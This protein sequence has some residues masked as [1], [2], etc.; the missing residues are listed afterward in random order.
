MDDLMISEC[1]ST[2]VT[3]VCKADVSCAEGGS[4]EMRNIQELL[5]NQLSVAHR[6]LVS[7]H[8]DVMVLVKRHM[9]AATQLETE[10]V[11][12]HIENQSLRE[13]LLAAGLSV[14]SS[15]RSETGGT[16]EV[17]MSKSH[18]ASRV[19][20]LRDAWAPKSASIVG[21]QHGHM[22][23]GA[24]ANQMS[25]TTRSGDW[26]RPGFGT[27]TQAH[28]MAGGPGAKST[29]FRQSISSPA[30]HER[31]VVGSAHPTVPV[32]NAAETPQEL[33]P[34][35]DPPGVPSAAWEDDGGG[36]STV[37]LSER[38]RRRIT[39]PATDTDQ[40]TSI[41][42]VPI[43][44]DV[45]KGF[46]SDRVVHE[47]IKDKKAEKMEAVLEAKALIDGVAAPH[48]A[49][50]APPKGA[51]PDVNAMKEKLR[52]AIGK[53]E[54]NVANFYHKSGIWQMM[55]RNSFFENLT[56][57]VIGVN[58]F[59]ISVDT[60]LNLADF[61]LEAEPVFQGAENL[62]CF[63]FSLE[64]F[65]RFM[66]FKGKRNGLKD[67]WFVFDTSLV[68]IMVLESWVLPI[69][70]LCGAGGSSGAFGNAGV[71]KLFRLVRLSRMARMARLFKA[72]PELMIMIK[73]MAVAM[74]SVF[75]TLCLLLCIVYVFAIA[76]VQLMGP[77]GALQPLSPSWAACESNPD[78]DGCV[79]F[80]TVVQSMNTLLLGGTMP[81]NAELIN[82]VGDE[83]WAM[84]FLVM[85]YILLAGLT[86]MNMLVG[87]LCEVVSVVS[88]VERET[89]LLNFVKGQLQELLDCT[90]LDVNHDNLISKSEFQALIEKPE[91][92]RA[93]QEVG[94]DVI[95]LVDFT[96][97]IFKDG[98]ELSFPDFMEVVLQLRGSN[99]A[100]VKDI[101]D[102][103]K[104]F[105]AEMAKFQ[106]YF[107]QDVK[108]KKMIADKAPIHERPGR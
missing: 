19:R 55:A 21:L 102:L 20:A 105:I 43:C 90:G 66:A 22:V 104:L 75:F 39:P 4:E 60:D 13:K 5:S 15:G 108:D 80:P 79:V 37:A 11:N 51:L 78:G 27:S 92:A 62:F 33:A 14:H 81:D 45:I 29:S 41:V 76:F 30:S 86:V 54:Y 98:R 38:E 25:P 77:R 31:I 56:L 93:L 72:M 74:R 83:H 97:F 36:R 16:G 34:E 53:P 73:G 24:E 50:A 94:V 64:W 35:M 68:T 9:E 10:N 85:I 3:D 44:E 59:W 89:L 7:N 61:I 49:A 96:D 12:L 69:L 107:E 82:G 91:A 48:H 2:N 57:F 88:A 101:V 58:A 100:T 87:V 52:Q 26:F 65:I 6:L 23:F 40:I 32:R 63:Y 71:L 95:G 70:I 8:E 46:D 99:T 103:R 42:P 1:Y 67:A 106:E 17:S 84:R 18:D 28:L 47:K